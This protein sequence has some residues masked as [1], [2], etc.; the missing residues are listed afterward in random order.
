MEKEI[1]AYN[2]RTMKY[3]PMTILHIHRYLGVLSISGT[4][5]GKPKYRLAGYDTVRGKEHKMSLLCDEQI[6]LSVSKSLGLHIED[7]IY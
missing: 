5:E 1:F 3:S 4:T 7:V 2:F 6:A